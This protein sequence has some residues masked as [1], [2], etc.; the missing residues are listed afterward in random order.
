MAGIIYLALQD[1]DKAIAIN[2]QLEEGYRNRGIVLNFIGQYERAYRDF[3]KALELDPDDG[4]AHS[5]REA[6][7]QVLFRERK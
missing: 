4:F 2:P 1:F 3:S 5:S 7:G 6:L